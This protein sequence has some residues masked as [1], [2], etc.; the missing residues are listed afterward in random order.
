MNSAFKVMHFDNDA[1]SRYLSKLIQGSEKGVL[2][3]QSKFYSYDHIIEERF[4]K[5]AYMTILEYADNSLFKSALEHAYRSSTPEDPVH[6]DPSTDDSVRKAF[7]ETL[8][9]ILRH[10]DYESGFRSEADFFISNSLSIG[11]TIIRDYLNQIFIDNFND[12]TLICHLL[13]S[14]SHIPYL[15]LYPAGITMATAALNHSNFEVKE[16]GIRC[17]ENWEEPSVIKI[18]ENI[19]LGEDWIERYK[20]KVID[21]L[22]EINANVHVGAQDRI[23]QMESKQYICRG[24]SIG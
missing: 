21:D 1:I 2:H 19:S 18:L 10:E 3:D 15:D 22:K 8:V 20:R 23:G 14:M 17:F 7:I 13:R 12:A 6:L 16:N 4:E 5:S 9:R 24:N 11:R